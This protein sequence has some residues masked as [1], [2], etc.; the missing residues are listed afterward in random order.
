MRTFIHYGPN[1]EI[2]AVARVEKM[3]EEL[4]NPFNPTDETH[5]VVE[6]DKSDPLAA[7]PGRELRAEFAVDMKSKRLR[8][9]MTKGESE[10][11]PPMPPA[12]TK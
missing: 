11:P 10:P 6:L 1:G 7:K 3:P 12:P 9:P 5:G 8:K 4:P 2:I